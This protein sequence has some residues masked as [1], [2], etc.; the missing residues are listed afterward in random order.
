MRTVNSNAIAI[1]HLL[2]S[3][4]DGGDIL[5]FLIFNQLYCLVYTVFIE[6]GSCPTCK[7]VRY[8]GG[9]RQRQ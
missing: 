6:Q 7:R 3:S 8:A 9:I 2:I 1:I 5:V 4:P